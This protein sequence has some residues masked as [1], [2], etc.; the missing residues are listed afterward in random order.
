MP[1]CHAG[2]REF[3]SRP[4][5]TLGTI[6]SLQPRKVY[7]RGFFYVL[8]ISYQLSPFSEHYLEVNN[9]IEMQPVLEFFSKYIEVEEK[10]LQVMLER[11]HYSTC[12]KKEYI[13]HQGEITNTIA[14]ITKGAVRYSYTDNKGS[15][16]AIGFGFENSPVVAFQSFMHQTP[17][18]VSI[19]TL[20]PTELLWITRKEFFGFLELFPKYEVGLRKVLGEYITKQ[21]NQSWLLRIESAKERYE[22]FC[23]QEPEIIQRV[24]LKYIASFLRMKLETLSRVR[25]GKL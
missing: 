12:K 6:K 3:E 1:A 13:Q 7:F 19:I 2:G 16:H 21:G 11:V 8:S 20:E 5:R 9:D 17:A 25:A 23:E 22:T 15:E 4:D 18:D 24:P 14:F 10:E